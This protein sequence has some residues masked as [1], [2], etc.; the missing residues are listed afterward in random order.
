MDGAIPKTS[1]GTIPG[2]SHGPR[3]RRW[4]APKLR[5]DVLGETGRRPRPAIWPLI[6]A[7]PAPLGR[8]H[9][10]RRARRSNSPALRAKATNLRR[11]LAPRVS[12]ITRTSSAAIRQSIADGRQQ[13]VIGRRQGLVPPMDVLDH[14]LDVDVE[15]ASVASVLQACT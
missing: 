4:R 5:P 9:P 7:P 13:Q 14:A 15:K 12:L 6:A 11:P 2:R 3:R 10:R 8:R 1:P